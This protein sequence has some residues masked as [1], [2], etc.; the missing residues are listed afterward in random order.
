MKRHCLTNGILL[1][2]G[3]TQ[4]HGSPSFAIIT[5]MLALSISYLF[6]CAIYGESHK[7]KVSIIRVLS[8]GGSGIDR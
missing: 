8:S 4:T 1:F 7:I 3:V 2:L 5:G 6:P